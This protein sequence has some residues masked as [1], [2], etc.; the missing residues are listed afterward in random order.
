MQRASRLF[1]DETRRRIDAAVAA[2]ESRTAVEIVPVVAT[3]SGRYDR[4]EDIA[5]LWLGIVA[6]VVAWSFYPESRAEAG[7]WGGLSPALEI[8]TY[9]AATLG[10][11][12]LGVILAMRVAPLRRLF[13]PRNEMRDDVATRARQVYFDSSV[14]HTAG[15]TG[16]LIYVSLFE[17]LA[18]VLG[19]RTIVER[20][21]EP[22]LDELCAT[23]TSAMRAD[24][25]GAIERTIRAAGE[26]LGA[27][28]P[29]A[30]DDVNELPDALVTLD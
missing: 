19:D 16:L 17:R 24:P 30:D 14:H 7:S 10:G 21:G 20:L 5:G 2:A 25:A 23:L 26:K 28:L 18:V 6:L 12:F 27:V 15:G 3:A 1:D 4:A 9:V 22:A 29:R 8:V 13:T 11:F